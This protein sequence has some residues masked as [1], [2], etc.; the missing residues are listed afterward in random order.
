M[1]DACAGSCY[2][3]IINDPANAEV[4]VSDSDTDGLYIQLFSIHGLIRGDAPELGRDADTGGQVKYV[5]ELARSLACRDDVVRVDLVTRLI[6]D[7]AVSPVYAEEIE[8]LSDKARIVRIQCGGRKYL[9]KE[10]LWPHLDEFVDKT[11]R[12]IK[13]QGRVPDIFHGHYADAGY[14]A[15]ELATIFGI[16]FIFTGHSMGR[17][18]KD[19]LTVEGMSAD[20]IN[21][22]YHI[23]RRIRAEER[24]IKD[25]EAI[26][27]ST[28]HEINK[29]YG[30]YD[31]FAVGTFHVI[32]PGIDSVTFYPYYNAQL[33]Y[34][35]EDEIV[36]QARVLLLR[37]LSRFW[38]AP[39]KPFILALCRPDQRKNIS[40][41]IRAYGKDP[42]LKAIANLAIFAGIRKDI[43]M[44]EDNERQVL[45]EMLLLMDRYDLY[46]RLAIPKKHDFTTEVPELYRLCADKRGVFV[47]PALVE[48]F[49]LT[50]IEASSC[51]LPIIATREGGPED[52]VKNCDNGILVDPTEDSDIATACRRI[53]VDPELWERYSRNGINGVREHYSWPSH[54]RK[55]MV[56]IKRV[57]ARVMEGTS[58]GVG[59]EVV[60]VGHR[61]TR[62][63]RLLIT[64]VD[65]TLVGDETSLVRLLAI[66]KEH[67]HD[68]AW[69]VATG[70]N[71]NRTL[72][73]LAEYGVPMPD[74]IIAAVGT[75]IFYGPD[76]I[77]DNGWQRHIGYQWKP[78]DVSDILSG[79]S[80][81]YPQDDEDQSPFKISYLMEDDPALLA[82]V[83]HLL[84]E[85]NIRYN[86]EFSNGQFL[87]ILPYRAS[88][89]KAVRYLS[90]KWDTPLKRIMVCGDSGNDAEMLRGDTCGLV[91]GNYSHELEDMRGLKRMRFSREEYAA[92]IIDGLNYYKWVH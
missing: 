92:G 59:R 25:A 65:N 11:L 13:Q 36:K 64:D 49:G 1:D 71:L 78:G 90:Y 31:N 91:V 19:K 76:L 88:K 68:I 60:S 52:I 4:Q 69:G 40:G 9:R 39:E 6:K 38:V 70:R 51:G 77:C 57:C 56:V 45:T 86:L 5:L 63:G 41:L 50:I 81:L 72:G 34:D 10:L 89:G 28:S 18:K 33:D 62:V 87:D 74:F 66:L 22:R 12:F 82:R 55:T 20:D 7:R 15:R 80:F 3:F 44:M 24:V 54:C 79:L 37:E 46:G 85:S 16:P 73:A 42:E 48:P 61:L 58:A 21:R 2:D 67:E 43:S 23:D 75:E 35:A 83:H 84:Q 27:T 53:L 17:H 29:Q 47:N 8:P 32:P 26:I 14:V 30:L